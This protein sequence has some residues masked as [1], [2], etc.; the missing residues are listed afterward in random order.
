MMLLNKLADF[1]QLN[2]GTVFSLLST[3]MGFSL[4]QNVLIR[5][6]D[7]IYTAVVADFGLSAK[8][9]DPL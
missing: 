4:P 5:R 3:Q 1:D 7:N 8:I 6:E 2:F 9:P